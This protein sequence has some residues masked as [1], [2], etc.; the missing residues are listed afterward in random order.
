MNAIV[1]L[2]LTALTHLGLLLVFV[3]MPSVTALW[4]DARKLTPFG[5]ALFRT[6]YLYVGLCLV[7]SG[8]GSWVFARDL[9]SGT[10]LARGVCGF[11]TA[12]WTLRLVAAIWILDV[13]PY[14]TNLGWRLGYHTTNVVFSLLPV[15][16]GWLT[17]RPGAAS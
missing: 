8:I 14:L 3:I 4:S 15:L 2:R 12:F 13:K 5:R 1:L 9:A 16:F 17:F 6:Y 7:A 10:A 11:L